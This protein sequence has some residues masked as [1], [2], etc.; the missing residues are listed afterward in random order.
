[1]S[2]RSKIVLIVLGVM[3]AYA[4]MAHLVIVAVVRPSF[5]SLE[6]D[7]AA[8]DMRRAVVALDA[9]IG[10]LDALCADWSG[11]DDTCRFVQAPYEQYVEANL[12]EDTF[13]WNR[14]DLIYIA[15][16]TGQA[17]WTRGYDPDSGKWIEFGHFPPD[18]LPQN[19]EVLAHLTPDA[20][21]RGRSVKG[22]FLT[23]RGPMLVS[24]RSVLTSRGEGPAVGTIIM[25]RMLTADLV[26]HLADQAL[27]DLAL[28]PLRLA[29]A[30]SDTP[31]L[32]VDADDPGVL[33]VVDTYP[34]LDREPALLLTVDTPRSVAERGRVVANIAWGSIVLAELVILLA[35]LVS[36]RHLIIQPVTALS[37]AVSDL[38]GSPDLSRRL[39]PGGDDELG[40]LANAANA[41]LDGLESA[42]EERRRMEVRVQ[43]AQKLESLSV[44]A[45]SIAHKFNNLLMTVLGNIELALPAVS[46]DSRARECL[47]DA[48]TAAKQA[49]DLS[50]MMLTY[51][52]KDM[53]EKQELDL[54]ALATE[55]AGLLP[56]T[57]P[58]NVR[59]EFQEP[60]QSIPVKANPTHMRQVIVNVVM[61]AAEAIGDAPGR[62]S[63][64]VARGPRGEDQGEWQLAQ[65]QPPDDG[66]ATLEVTDDGCGMDEATLARVFDPFFTTRFTGRGLGMAA[67][68]GIARA[69][70]GAVALK[71]APGQGTSVRVV[72]P[73]AGGTGASPDGA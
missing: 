7:T 21:G 30:P 53:V 5:D 73:L 29:S 28:T 32:R 40:R 22:V 15:D 6:R 62:V 51:V 18:R 8:K 65:G 71:S 14:L 17:V 43:Q 4:L 59:F 16:M 56:N 66:C 48:E 9:E 2:L 68:L 24:A 41:M 64:R 33:H 36:V 54:A 47:D 69:H 58:N 10:Q 70:G 19:H 20:S 72:L 13:A 35:L 26:Q 27:I 31:G 50:K 63:L 45:G 34:G 23:G 55:M 25:G 11:R 12:V 39:P 52:G 1:L 38:A 37:L 46:C 3:I 60:A 49:A 44:M 42:A 61:N 67:V 57:L